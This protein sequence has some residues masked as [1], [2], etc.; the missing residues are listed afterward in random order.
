MSAPS[1]IGIAFRSPRLTAALLT[2]AFG[3]LYLAVRPPLFD[4]DGYSSWLD[5]LGPGAYFNTNPHHLLE[6]SID[7]LIVKASGALAIDARVA[8][9]VLG[10]TLNCLTIYALC[11][12]LADV[13]SS[14]FFA[15][16]A[17]T[18]V[19]TSPQFWYFGLQNKPYPL[20][21]LAFVL[22]LWGWNTHDRSIPG[23]TRLA[24]AGGFLALAV[25]MQQAAI[26]LVGAGT[27]AIVLAGERPLTRRVFVA[28]IWVTGVGGVVLL[29]Y[30]LMWVRIGRDEMSFFRWTMWYLQ[31]VHP[32][33][34]QFPTSLIRAV[35]GLS[36]AIVQSDRLQ[37]FVETNWTPRAILGTY[38]GLGIAGILG[39]VLIA[40]RRGYRA[41]ITHL[42]RSDCLL[43]V[44]LLSIVFWAAFVIAWEPATAYYWAFI[45]LP[46]VVCWGIIFRDDSRD[47]G[48]IALV[49][50]A[51]VA[52]NVT[53]NLRYDRAL[54]KNYP[55]PLL[56]A[57]RHNLG[58]KDIFV[59]LGREEWYASMDYEL[60]FDC[61]DRQPG[62]FGVPVIQDYVLPAHGS[63]WTTNLR[64]KFDDTLDAGGRVFIAGHLLN[65]DSYEDINGSVSPFSPYIDPKTASINGDKLHD[66]IQGV[67]DDYTLVPSD[68][69][70]GADSYFL[71]EKSR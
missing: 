24:L 33:Q 26:F 57:I 49:V 67:L 18:L 20:M 60:L 47:L 59:V 21:Y 35:L 29:V 65:D 69:R 50:A 2:L 48:K 66:Q 15:V 5:A 41:R 22:Y 12:L 62:H 7:V 71:L 45:L 56:A 4:L 9:Q 16:I 13:T 32:L 63:D 51:I 38:A 19:A 43:A 34:F 64:R 27:L 36:G 37:D 52:W 14:Q 42:I 30:V 54:S 1:P 28:I 10:I 3:A 23:A 70:I 11:L 61:L 68:F 58:P 53:F 40:G 25:C 6:N 8:L 31:S 55:P 17:T 39:F 46:G 44:S